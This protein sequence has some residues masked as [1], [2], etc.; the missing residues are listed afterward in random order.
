VRFL[1]V[2][3]ILEGVVGP[4]MSNVIWLNLTAPAVWVRAPLMLGAALLLT[5]FFARVP[6]A[7]IGLRSARDWTLTERSY[8]VQAVVIATIVFGAVLSDRWQRLATSDAVAEHVLLT[9]LPYFAFG[10]YQE[11]MYRGVLQTEL[12]RRLGRSAGILSSNAAY[13]FGPLHVYYL[14]QAAPAAPMFAATFA[15]GLFFAL[16]YYRSGNLWLP[17]TFHGLG[18]AFVQGT[19]G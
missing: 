9:A 16:L 12:I 13:T 14:W 6:L 17:A 19:V 1:L 3:V 15:I 18:N 2:F 11:V 5:R 4:R 7:A 8:L 10:F